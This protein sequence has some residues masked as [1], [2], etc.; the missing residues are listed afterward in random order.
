MPSLAGPL[1]GGR[2]TKT[3]VERSADVA[4]PVRRASSPIGTRSLPGMSIPLT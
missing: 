4:T 1:G 3:L 2:Q